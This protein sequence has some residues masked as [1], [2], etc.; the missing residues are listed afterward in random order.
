MGV[1]FM[2]HVFLSQDETAQSVPGGL[3]ETK[4]EVGFMLHVFFVV[5]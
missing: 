2:V 5:G 3:A 4:M 1:C